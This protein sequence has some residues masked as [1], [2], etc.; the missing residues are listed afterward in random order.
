[1]VLSG[2]IGCQYVPSFWHKSEKSTQPGA[3]NGTN[4]VNDANH[5]ALGDVSLTNHFETVVMLDKS[6]SCT[7]V[8]HMADIRNVQLTLSLESRAAGKT[9]AISITRVSVKPDKLMEV[10]LGETHISFTPKLVTR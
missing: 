2:T 5:C 7:L 3:A 6:R 8:P 4:W 9:K 1:M 10:A